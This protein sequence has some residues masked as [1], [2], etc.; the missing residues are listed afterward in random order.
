MG[1]ALTMVLA[2]MAVG[3]IGTVAAGPIMRGLFYRAEVASVT[4]ILPVA[5]VLLLVAALAAHL[6]ARRAAKT[7]PA[8][9]L[10]VEA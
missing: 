2:G 8:E 7:D 5:A 1:Q 3:L 4:T 9:C 6:P 10:R